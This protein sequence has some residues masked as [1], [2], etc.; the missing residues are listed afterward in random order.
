MT[1]ETTDKL[2]K[3]FESMAVFKDLTQTSLFKTLGLPS[4][5]RDWL[6]QRFE[7]ADGVFDADEM[8]SFVHEFGLLSFLSVYII[9]KSEIKVNRFL[10]I[11]LFLFIN[12]K[13]SQT[14]PGAGPGRIRCRV[15][16]C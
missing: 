7:N 9:S 16:H 8:L 15:S 3:C 6:L 12:K 13:F 5:M 4:F 1:Q 10:K 11:F 2:R 14:K